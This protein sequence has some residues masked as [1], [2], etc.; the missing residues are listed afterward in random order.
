MST[1]LDLT[2]VPTL[3]LHCFA[4][5]NHPLKPEHLYGLFALGGIIVGS[6]PEDQLL[7][8]KARLAESAVTYRTFIKTWASFL[9]SE[10]TTESTIAA[11]NA[12]D[13]GDYTR[14]LF[15]NVNL[16]TIIVDNATNTMEQTDKFG[17][18]FPGEYRKTFRLETLVRDLLKTEKTFEK[19]VAKFDSTIEAA[20]KKHGCTSFKTVIAYRTGLDVGIV[21]EADA[22][23][24]FAT[25][26]SD[27][28]WFGP[29]AKKL[30]DFLLRRAMI[31]SIPWGTPV[32]IHTGLGDTDIVAAKCNPANLTDLLKDPEVMPAKIVLIHGG[33]PYTLEAGWLANVLPNVYIELSCGV[34]PYMEPAVGVRRYSDLL[35]WVPLTKLIFGS[36]AGDYPEFHWY[37]ARYAKQKM[38]AAL[39]ELVDNGIFTEAEAMQ[40]AENIFYNNAKALLGI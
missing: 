11:R 29:Y 28:R 1:I 32:L 4:Y 5:E 13:F 30:R 31:K 27:V 21:S 2:H 36:D 6:V 25:R 8:H 23:A 18:T 14:S 7:P 3:D 39:G 19:L 37:Y 38:G 15:E 10:A 17:R 20:V 24:D 34:V 33:F 12:S 35:Q 16:K 22:K 26:E 9:G 40:E